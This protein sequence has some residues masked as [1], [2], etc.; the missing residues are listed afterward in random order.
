MRGGQFFMSEVPLCGE[1][2]TGRCQN[3]TFKESQSR[4][5]VDTCKLY[6]DLIKWSI[7]GY[8]AYNKQPP[9]P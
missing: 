5:A 1:G 4:N 3:R 2:D 6:N 9:P 8:L 7:Q